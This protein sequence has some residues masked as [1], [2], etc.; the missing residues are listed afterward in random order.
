MA[1]TVGQSTRERTALTEKI[2]AA[3]GMKP[4]ATLSGAAAGGRF[5]AEP[6]GQIL[7]TYDPT[8]GA[9]IAHVRTASKNT[10]RCCF[11]ESALTPRIVTASVS[12]ARATLRSFSACHCFSYASRI[13]FG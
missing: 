2:L 1:V 4:G 5:I 11:V 9:V 8:T 3:F 10:A 13:A 7:D 6:H 12:A